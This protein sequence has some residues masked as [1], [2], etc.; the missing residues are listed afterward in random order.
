MLL[1]TPTETGPKHVSCDEVPWFTTSSS[2]H[3]R[4]G[5]QRGVESLGI[6]RSLQQISSDFLTS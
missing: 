6:G 5:I 2:D 1:S 4:A 3:G